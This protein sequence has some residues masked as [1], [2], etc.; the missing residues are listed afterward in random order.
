MTRYAFPPEPDDEWLK[1]AANRLMARTPDGWDDLAEPAARP[2]SWIGRIAKG[3]AMTT[4]DGTV[5][6]LPAQPPDGTTVVNGTRSWTR[7]G[8]TWREVDGSYCGRWANL[9]MD[10]GPV[11]IPGDGQPEPDPAP[12]GR[13]WERDRPTRLSREEWDAAADALV[14]AQSDLGLAA[15]QGSPKQVPWATRIRACAVDA[16]ADYEYVVQRLLDEYDATDDQRGEAAQFLQD[17]RTALTDITDAG[18][19]IDRSDLPFRVI[20]HAA[21][22]ARK[23]Q[24]RDGA[25]FQW[26]PPRPR[27]DGELHHRPASRPSLG[28]PA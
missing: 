8:E 27:W 6:G 22:M 26:S 13:A 10:H 9:L 5:I 28:G 21:S 20:Y 2:V 1:T 17:C 4:T 24:R 14:A 15:L 12:R 23:R 3:F 11:E 7:D 16:L 25:T 18:Q 19:W